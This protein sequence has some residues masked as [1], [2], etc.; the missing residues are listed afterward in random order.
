MLFWIIFIVL[1]IIIGWLGGL[2]IALSWDYYE[3]DLSLQALSVFVGP[4]AFII[5]LIF[6]LAKILKYSNFLD[7]VTKKLTIT[8]K[9]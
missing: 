6:W 1:W 4:F 3:Y 5:S 9:K 8:L 2:I 7:K